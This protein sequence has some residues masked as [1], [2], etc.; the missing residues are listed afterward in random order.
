LFAWRLNVNHR[1]HP[2]AL[3]GAFKRRRL[4]RAGATAAATQEGA[5]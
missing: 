4:L 1:W 2:L 3:L 5:P